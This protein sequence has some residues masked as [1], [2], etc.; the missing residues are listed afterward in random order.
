MEDID[1]FYEEKE[2]AIERGDFQTA[3]YYQQ[4]IDQAEIIEDEEAD[5]DDFIGEMYD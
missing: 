1:R 4:L 3:A 2:E 5:H